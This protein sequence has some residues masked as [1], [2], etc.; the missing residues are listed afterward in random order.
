M[1]YD[2]KKQ[3]LLEK[4]E[5]LNEA[6]ESVFK[7]DKDGLVLKPHHKIEV[8]EL[9]KQSKTILGKIQ[10]GEFEIAVIGQED[11][12]K[13][14]LLN[15][16][17]K[18]DIFPSNSGR[19][20]YTSTKLISGKEDKAE[21]K[22]YTFNEFED[23]FISRLE[24]IGVD[25]KLAKEKGFRNFSPNL[26]SYKNEKNN[27]DIKDLIED[28]EET[29]N[30]RDEIIEL[31]EEKGGETVSFDE[32]KLKD[33]KEY[34]TGTENDKS[35]P[36]AT[37]EIVIY[38]SKLNAMPNSIIYDVPGFN[39]PTK[40]HKEQTAKMLKES[41]SIIFITDVSSPNLKGDELQ[42]LSKGDDIYGVSLKDKV[43]VFGNKYDRANNEKEAE[44]NEKKFK[45]DVL[46]KMF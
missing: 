46:E 10:K 1:S 23:I 22:L 18:T 6:I 31:L 8:E 14:S 9:Q 13:S 44:D 17:I 16:L 28:A 4:S 30:F 11:S 2:D 29:L 40:L 21:V 25:E 36:R 33:V 12:G 5:K 15:A 43:F 41:D 26:N 19:T 35:K 7:S 27:T 3:K 24:A 45:K 42:T 39:S 20:T 37:K 38:S 32:T 34:I